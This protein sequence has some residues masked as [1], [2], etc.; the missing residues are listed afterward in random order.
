MKTNMK[1]NMK[2]AIAACG[3]LA[4]VSAPLTAGADTFVFSGK[5]AFGNMWGS[6]GSLYLEAN[7]FENATKSK[8]DKTTSAGASVY[9]S[10]YDGSS[11]WYGYGFTELIEFAKQGSLPEQVSASGSVPVTWD[12]YCGGQQ[13]FTE[14]VPFD[15]D[16]SALTDQASSNWGT[17]HYE[18]GNTKVNSHFDYSSAPAAPNASSISSPAFG[19]V[20][21]SYGYVGRS[22]SHDV[23]IIR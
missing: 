12:D 2:S 23:Q 13:S 19:T 15:M 6:N 7:A 14:T 21:P 10:N 9:G 3:F 17:T 5:G 16:L 22:K 20:N 11:C 8:S 18:Y 1:T 4:A